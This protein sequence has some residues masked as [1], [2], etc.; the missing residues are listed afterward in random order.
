MTVAAKE[1]LEQQAREWL[2]KNDYDMFLTKA[3]GASGDAL[4]MLMGGFG[5]DVLAA[6]LKEVREEAEFWRQM[7]FQSPFRKD[8]Y[9]ERMDACERIA[10]RLEALSK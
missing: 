7:M 5:A 8:I 2:K 6:A 10:A 1:K 3:F 9:W 4:C